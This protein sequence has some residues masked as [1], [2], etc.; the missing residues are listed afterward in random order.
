M[1]NKNIYFQNPSYLDKGSSYEWTSE[2]KKSS[3]KVAKNTSM[4]IIETGAT[5]RRIAKHPSERTNATKASHDFAI[6]YEIIYDYS[7]NYPEAS[8]DITHTECI[9]Y[10]VSW[11]GD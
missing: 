3:Y 5:N 9:Y 2:L 11:C 1:N 4:R 8:D 10:S 7:N 6:V